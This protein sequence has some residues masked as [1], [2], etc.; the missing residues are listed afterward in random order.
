MVT[1][2]VPKV[3]LPWN[4]TVPVV[5]VMVVVAASTALWKVVLPEL[6]MVKSL[7]ATVVPVMAPTVPALRPKLKAPLM[8]AKKVMFAPADALPV[9]ATLELA[10]RVTAPVMETAPDVVVM[11]WPRVTPADPLRETVPEDVVKVPLVAR[12]PERD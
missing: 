7:I 3:R 2:A 5:L 6:E 1:S 4:A 8:P 10:A 9:V 11:L 12:V